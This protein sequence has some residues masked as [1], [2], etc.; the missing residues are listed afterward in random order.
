MLIV[1]E[2]QLTLLFQS[3]PPRGG[4]QAASA[5]GRSKP[6]FNPRPRE[7]ANPNGKGVHL[8]TQMFQSAPPRGGEPHCRERDNAD[9]MFQSAPPRGG[10]REITAWLG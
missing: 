7:G 10:E 2:V 4:E 9:T 1:A 5:R 8:D 6:C 3:A